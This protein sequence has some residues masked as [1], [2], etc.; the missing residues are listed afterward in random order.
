MGSG[1]AYFWEMH[2]ELM[3]MP[4]CVKMFLQTDGGVAQLSGSR[5]ERF[6]LLSVSQCEGKL[7]FG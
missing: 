2:A 6:E 5:R 4:Q 7:S 1:C 3:M